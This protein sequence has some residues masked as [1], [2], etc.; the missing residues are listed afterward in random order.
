MR[1]P[2]GLPLFLNATLKL[3]KPS[4]M[5]W[6]LF[7]WPFPKID[8][9]HVCLHMTVHKLA[10]WIPSSDKSLYEE[11]MCHCFPSI[12]CLSGQVYARNSLSSKTSFIFVA[13]SFAG[14]NVHRKWLFYFYSHYQNGRFLWVNVSFKTSNICLMFLDVKTNTC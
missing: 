4:S 7:A 5:H 2:P 3:G 12:R 8:N 6:R 14:K 1:V 11:N 9:N 10:T 13:R